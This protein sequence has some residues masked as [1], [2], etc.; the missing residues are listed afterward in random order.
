MRK[1]IFCT[2]L[3]RAAKA[4][5]K[6]IVKARRIQRINQGRTPFICPL[7]TKH[8]I[9]LLSKL[10]FYSCETHRTAV[11]AGYESVQ[12]NL[13]PV[14][15][16]SSYQFWSDEAY[17]RTIPH[18]PLPAVRDLTRDGRWS[19]YDVGVLQLANAGGGP[20]HSSITEISS[21]GIACL[22]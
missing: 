4:G 13:E 8:S 9:N 12:F 2:G 19:T 18:W 17:G 6:S 11:R 21:E 22:L 3:T 7:C 14:T 20:T 16:P 10:F 1:T 15:N 5:Q